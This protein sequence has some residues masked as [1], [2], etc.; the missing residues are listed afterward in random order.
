MAWDN[1]TAKTQVWGRNFGDRPP[2]TMRG[3]SSMDATTDGSLLVTRPTAHTTEAAE[4]MPRY[5]K[6]KSVVGREEEDV[7]VIQNTLHPFPLRSRQRRR[8]SVRR[9]HHPFH[10]IPHM[11]AR[12]CFSIDS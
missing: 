9:T 8:R 10:T 4:H 5:S 1:E 6:V 7:G 2:L 3:E 11:N 12:Y